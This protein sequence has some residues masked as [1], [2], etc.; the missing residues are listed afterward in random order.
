M[1]Y[2]MEKDAMSM[3]EK[4]SVIIPFYNS[5]EYLRASI[6]QLQK[7]SYS[8]IELLLLDD[9]STD[10]GEAEIEDLIDNKIVFYYC[11]PHQGVSAARNKGIEEASV[12]S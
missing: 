6:I 12:V 9:G 5:K 3:N 4:V 11:L 8:N 7:Q 10:G 2:S 1:I